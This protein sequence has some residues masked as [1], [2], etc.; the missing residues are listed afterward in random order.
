MFKSISALQR[1]TP[2]P[3][4]PR[5]SLSFLFPLRC[6]FYRNSQAKISK[7]FPAR[8][9][10]GACPKYGNSDVTLYTDNCVRQHTQQIGVEIIGKYGGERDIQG[11]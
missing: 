2:P 10:F 11:N 8:P 6:E 9:G 3:S 5:Y 1:L 4:F 7:T